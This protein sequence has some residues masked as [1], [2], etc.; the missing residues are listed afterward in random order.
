VSRSSTPVCCCFRKRL[1]NGIAGDRKAMILG[2]AGF[3]SSVRPVIL[4]RRL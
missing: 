3:T 4:P 1:E 2:E